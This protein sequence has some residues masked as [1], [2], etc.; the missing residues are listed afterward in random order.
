MASHTPEPR[1][2]TS[3]SSSP[4]TCRPAAGCAVPVSPPAFPSSSLYSRQQR[5]WLQQAYARQL[6]LHCHAALVAAGSAR[7]TPTGAAVRYAPAHPVPVPTALA[8]HNA[9]DDLP[10]NQNVAPDGAFVNP[11]AAN[12]NLRMNAQGGPVMEDDHDV[13]RDWLDWLYS[14]ARFGVLLAIVY[15][16]SNLSRFLLVASTL[17]LMYLHAAGW[18]PFR[19]IQEPNPVRPA[20]V[21]QNQ[22]GQQENRLDGLGGAGPS[23]GPATVVLVP[24]HRVSAMWTAWVFFKTFFS[25]LIP[26]VPQGG[27]H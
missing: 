26:E 19:R 23:G 21:Q 15:F 9:L 10:V 20:V 7:L 4:P 1:Q 11:G 13:Q 22:D 18:F 3:S 27:A 16:N 17:L 25:S 2:R 8:D 5:L 12:Q 24:P 6:Y 14:V